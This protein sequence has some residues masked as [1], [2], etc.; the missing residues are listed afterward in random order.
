MDQEEIKKSIAERF[1]NLQP[2]IQKVI[3]SPDYE[4]NLYDI[5]KKYNLS[6]E[7]TRELELNTTLVLIGSIHPEDYN[8]E[9]EDDIKLPTENM[10]KIVADIDEKIFKDIKNLLAS[11]FNKEDAE[12]IEFNYKSLDGIAKNIRSMLKETVRVNHA[13]QQGDFLKN[14]SHEIQVILK[15]G[16]YYQ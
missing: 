15:N 6:L 12:E 5:S 11:N 7:Q 13:S 1:D 8:R 16:G 4:K 9:L 10:I 3:L 2:E 14:L